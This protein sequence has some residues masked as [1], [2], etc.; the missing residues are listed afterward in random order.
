MENDKWLIR[1]RALLAQA[2]DPAATPA[3]A[4]TFLAKATKLIAKLGIDTAMLAA[5]ES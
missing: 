5:T 3:E 2:E 1:I 4:E